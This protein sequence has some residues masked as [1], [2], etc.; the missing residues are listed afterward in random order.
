MGRPSEGWVS[1]SV[2]QE[3]NIETGELLFEWR[4][5]EHFD[6]NESYMTNPFA[7]YSAEIPFD[8]FHI[9]S[10]DKD[11]AG[12]Y[13]VSS[14]HFHSITCISPSGETLWVLGGRHNEFN[15]MSN[16]KA[17]DFKWQHSAK[18]LSPEEGILVLFDNGKGGTLH[19]DAA[20]SRGL[21]LQLNVE[22]RTVQV[23]ETYVSQQGILSASQGSLQILPESD[24]AF[25]GWG[26]AAAYSEFLRDGTLICETHLGASWFYWWE[27][28]KSYRTMKALT[29]HGVPST[30]PQAVLEG[31]EIY[32]SWNGATDVAFWALE[33][34]HSRPNIEESDE[35]SPESEGNLSNDDFFSIDIIPKVGFEG[36]FTLSSEMKSS[37]QPFSRYRVAALDANQDPISHSSPVI[38]ARSGHGFL[39]MLFFAIFALAGSSALVGS[40]LGTRSFMKR[41][42]SPSRPVSRW[43]PRT[44]LNWRFPQWP[45]KSRYQSLSTD[46]T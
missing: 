15:D 34:S 8:F 7:G 33:V 19:V 40:I 29:W 38:A 43:M 25:V 26:S 21:I 41:Q 6:P 46:E 22:D 12:N 30:P 1:D 35:S 17:T 42:N 44:R 2:F 32:V 31:D 28:M 11:S 3:I 10:I 39:S 45:T 4:A 18:W 14:R 23:L 20:H 27:R 5:S 9:N 37:E 13:I 16:G 36:V 24:Q